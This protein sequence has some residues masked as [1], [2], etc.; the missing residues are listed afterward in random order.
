MRVICRRKRSLRG[1]ALKGGARAAES[2]LLAILLAA[3]CVAGTTAASA[4]QRPARTLFAWGDNTYGELGDGTTTD[5][6]VP[7]PVDLPA[8]TRVTAVA[9]GFDDT[10][11]LAGPTPCRHR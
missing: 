6:S 3:L 8:G 4:A 10:L 1:R 11:A 9:G 5:R 7:V 2:V